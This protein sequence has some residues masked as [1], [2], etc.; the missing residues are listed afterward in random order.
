MAYLQNSMVYIMIRA[1]VIN[2]EGASITST[3]AF[4]SSSIA[5]R[6][7]YKWALYIWIN[8]ICALFFSYYGKRLQIY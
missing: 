6:K 7:L 4:T 8:K 5:D 3:S 1:M 2:L